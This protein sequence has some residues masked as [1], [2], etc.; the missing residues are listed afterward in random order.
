ML[1]GE[2]HQGGDMYT[3]TAD[4]HCCTPETSTILSTG[5]TLIKKKKQQQKSIFLSSSDID[6]C[7]EL[8]SNPYM[9]SVRC[10]SVG[11][12]VDEFFVFE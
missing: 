8:G 9:C 4:S 3:L 5:Y 1:G 7:F 6:I 12:N 2:A 10:D 11:G